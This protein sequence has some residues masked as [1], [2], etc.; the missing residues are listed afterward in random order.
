MI[1]AVVV[2]VVAILGGYLIYLYV[3]SARIPD[4]EALTVTEIHSG[5]AEPGAG[6]EGEEDAS[7]EFG[8]GSGEGGESAGSMAVMRTGITYKALTYNI[9][10]GAYDHAFSYFMEES[11]TARGDKVKGLMSRAESED[12]VKKNVGAAIDAAI[13]QNPDIALFQEVDKNASRS[14]KINQLHMMSDAFGER[15]GGEGESGGSLAEIYAGNF[16]SGWL[17]WPPTRPMGAVNDSGIATY[18]RYRVNAAERVSLPID[19]S[20][21]GRITDIDRCFT[22][23]RLPVGGSGAEDSGNSEAQSGEGTV[24]SGSAGS[25]VVLINVHLSAYDAGEKMRGEQ[26]KKLA[27]YM[28]EERAKGNWV[29]AGGDWNQSFPGSI[30][31]FTGRMAI[32][33]WA[34]PFDESALPEGFTLITAD[35]ADIIATCRDTSI[36]W[37]PGV[38]YETILDGWI[39]SD[40]VTASAENIETD[41]QASDHNPV[42]LTFVLQ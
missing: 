10:F 24:D 13:E 31:A 12:S 17:L 16:H 35:N 5:Q 2:T 22:V 40:D 3:K 42:Q 20:F 28:A 38:S 19:E 27:D 32:P 21:F 36:P 33:A 37:T 8:S 7:A 25:E 26:M 4:N 41:Y 29:I 30:D 1:V 15:L 6:G 39:V 18:S 11:T 34:K 9:G 14:Y 23:A